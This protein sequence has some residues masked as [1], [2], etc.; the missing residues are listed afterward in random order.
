MGFHYHKTSSPHY[1]QSNRFAESCF[2]IIKHMRQ[3]AKYSGTNPMIA[4][5]HLK[6]IPVDV[7]L[8]STSEML[9]YCKICTTIPSRICNTDP[10]ALQVQ[11]YLA[12]SGKQPKSYADKCSKQLAPFYA[13]QPIAA[14]DTLSKMW[15]PTTVVHVFPKNSYQGCTANGTIYCHT[16]CYLWECSVKFNDTVPKSP[17]A[18]S[19]QAHTRFPRAV[20]Q[21][22][23][24]T[25]QTPQSVAPVTPEPKL[26]VPAS[27]P[28]ATSKVTSVPTSTTTPR[29]APVQPQRAGHTLTAPKHLIAEM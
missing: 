29:V 5:Q 1:T 24:T 13:V 23:T 8:P 15:I 7:T 21:L 16:K 25:Q 14:F 6:V 17:S 11:G 12:D 26:A 19:D 4:L 20:P 2:R 9:H 22:T 18:T 3:C 10:A 28:T 27:T